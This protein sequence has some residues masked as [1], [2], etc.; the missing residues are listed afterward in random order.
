MRVTA[1]NVFVLIVQ[2]EV[3]SGCS[4]LRNGGYLENSRGI[5]VVFDD[6]VS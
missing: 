4:I 6:T 5:I 2:P 1:V 3:F